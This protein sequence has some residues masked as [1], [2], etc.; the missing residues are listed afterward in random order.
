VHGL[1]GRREL[2]AR[3][4]R[5]G[6]ELLDVHADLP[7]VLLVAQL[8]Q[9]LVV[10]DLQPLPRLRCCRFISSRGNNDNVGLKQNG[11]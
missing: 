9:R 8:R 11:A 4:L 1:V 3:S 7:A 6:L 10:L 5:R 2:R